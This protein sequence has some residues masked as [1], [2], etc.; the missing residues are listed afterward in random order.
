M[1]D[2]AAVDG[3]QLALNIGLNRI[4]GLLFLWLV[5]LLLSSKLNVF[6]VSVFHM[7]L[8]IN[9]TILSLI[10]HLMILKVAIIHN[11]LVIIV[12]YDILVVLIVLISGQRAMRIDSRNIII[13]HYRLQASARWNLVIVHFALA[14]EVLPGVIVRWIHV[15]ILNI[16]LYW[17]IVRIL[18]LNSF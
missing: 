17:F 6:I 4:S 13:D 10:F 11:L 15:R 1:P 2:V 8:Y 14:V 9:L 18:L 12:H 7:L 16:G 5:L 3:G